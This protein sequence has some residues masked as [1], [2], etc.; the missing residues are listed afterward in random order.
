MIF[1]NNDIIITS[2]NVKKKLLTNSYDLLNIKYMSFD[3]LKKGLLFDYDK[4]AI[5]YLKSKY[6]YK[7][8]IIKEYLDSLYYIDDVDNDK[9]LFLKN[10]KNELDDN[11]L[12][13]YDSLFKDFLSNCRIVVYGNNHIS[14][15]EKR[16]LDSIKDI[17]EI[18]I[19][20]KE[21]RVIKSSLYEFNLIYD[22]IDF[23]ARKI[24]DLLKKNISVNRIKLINVSENY[25]NI[26]KRIFNMYNL[27][28]D[29]KC[30]NILA[31]QI[32]VFFKNNYQSDLRNTLELIKKEYDLSNSRNYFIYKKI[33]GVVN[34]YY[35]VNDYN[36]VYEMILDDLKNTSYQIDYDSRSIEI[37]DIKDHIFED[38]CYYFLMSFNEGIIPSIYK[39]DSYLDDKLCSLLQIETSKEKNII[40]KSIITK[41]INDINNLVITYHKQD[42]SDVKLIS[43]L[44][45]DIDYILLTDTKTYNYSSLSN[46]IELCKKI[47]NLIK[48]DRKEDYL[49]NLANTYDIPYNAYSNEYIMIKKDSLNK[50]INNKLSL[51]Y[52][53]LNSFFECSFKYYLDY[54]LK[55]S[56]Y[57]YTFV[58]YI[59]NVFHGIM[60]NIKSNN[61]YD[62][63]FKD[64]VDKCSKDYELSIK[65]RF[66]LNILKEKFEDTFN[67]LKSNEDLILLKDNVIE[68]SVVINKDNNVVVK[69]FVDKI[70]YNNDY[71]A[72]V[73]YKTGSINPSLDMLN[74]GLNMQLP[75]YLYLLN[76]DEEYKQKKLCGMFY[77]E[78]FNKDGIK[79]K[80]YASAHNIKMF[81]TTYLDSKIIKGLKTNLDGSLSKNSKVIYEED[82]NRLI[83]TIDNN[84][85]KALESILDG[86]FTI[87]PKVVN[88]KNISCQFCK[89]KEI[90]NVTPLCEVVLEKEEVGDIDE[91]Y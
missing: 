17:C 89:Y 73:D 9:V 90:C 3:D 23:I 63:L 24:I 52:T 79:F 58:Q 49:D 2:Q 59:G 88:N 13:I 77:Q 15:H 18:E 27:H 84:I 76:H 11:K 29:V 21:Y 12:L 54:I 44:I 32:G 28:I 20:E 65:E 37:V 81:D 26:I 70:Y 36:D 87:N 34:K 75:M 78:L 71:Y 14:F 19:V 82:I 74:N 33:L 4:R 45:K 72:F 56:K 69:G 55:V 61:S 25:I 80:G 48:Y 40:E 86:Q 85:D 62:E 39:N 1:K 38:D 50:L 91:L 22:E 30:H 6:N 31:T 7:I 64:S 41:I 8:D 10:I 46:K 66:L 57:E 43:P 42:L 35:F 53:S 5:H 67:I 60:E 16:M 83:S 51:S 68:K 47:D